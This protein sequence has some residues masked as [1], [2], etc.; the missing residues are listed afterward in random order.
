MSAKSKLRSAL[1]A[2]DDAMR[3]LKRARDSA[4]EDDNIRRAIREL[5][6]AEAYIKRAS[7]EIE[8]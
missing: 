7:R 8:D 6:D 5:D 4:P 1:S 2:I 3:A